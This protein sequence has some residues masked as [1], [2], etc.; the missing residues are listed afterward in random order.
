MNIYNILN[1]YGC[2]SNS[3]LLRPFSIYDGHDT[4]SGTMAVK[5]PINISTNLSTLKSESQNIFI[6]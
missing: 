2:G 6:S 5:Q 4:P 1:Y 3:R